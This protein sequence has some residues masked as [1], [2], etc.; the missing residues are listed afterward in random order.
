MTNS[1]YN[2]GE[3]HFYE[4]ATPLGLDD[5]FASPET[6]DFLVEFINETENDLIIYNYIS[7][8]NYSRIIKTSDFLLEPGG[9]KKIYY[10]S[11]KIKE[12]YEGIF[13]LGTSQN[14]SDWWLTLGFFDCKHQKVTLYENF[15]FEI[16]E[17]D[18]FD[19]EQ[20]FVKWIILLVMKSS[21]K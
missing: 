15:E 1:E 5:Y 10:N 16:K 7:D 2:N 19:T 8:F 12:N 21:A 20:S 11:A 4:D 9:T 6:S 13:T 14:G 18:N 3:T 17:Y